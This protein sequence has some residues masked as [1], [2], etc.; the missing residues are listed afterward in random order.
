MKMVPTWSGGRTCLRTPSVASSAAWSCSGGVF[1]PALGSPLRGGEE[2]THR[3]E[4][5]PHTGTSPGCT[6]KVRKFMSGTR[7]YSGPSSRI[8]EGC[9][10]LWPTG[11]CGHLWTPARGRSGSREPRR[12]GGNIGRGE[13]VKK[14]PG[15]PVCQSV[16]LLTGH[17]PLFPQEATLDRQVKPL[18]Q[19]NHRIYSNCIVIVPKEPGSNELDIIK[20]LMPSFHS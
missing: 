1:I 6:R 15:W 14:E 7:G 18:D 11:C 5:G 8:R 9:P 13:R 3:Q 4:N 16:C 19:L 2:G 17:R 12:E 20:I 10:V